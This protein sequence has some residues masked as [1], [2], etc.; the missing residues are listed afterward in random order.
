[1]DGEFEVYGRNG[2]GRVGPTVSRKVGTAR[3]ARTIRAVAPR[4]GALA[5]PNR[6]RIAARERPHPGPRT[7]PV[8]GRPGLPSRHMPA[9]RPRSGRSP[10]RFSAGP[11]VPQPAVRGAWLRA[12]GGPAPVT[13]PRV[14]ATIEP[15]A[16]A[17][18]GARDLA[19]LAAVFETFVAGAAIRRA[20]MAA[21]LLSRVA[22]PDDVRALRLA[23]RALD[24]RA[25]N[26]L[27]G[28]GCGPS[29]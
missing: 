9:P 19:R 3:T 6:E 5:P 18:W 8:L 20:T 14:L 2:S 27:L 26:A 12:R 29:A 21:S 23:L 13:L 24:S 17:D 15:V 25:A 4:P 28:R 10:G 7:A 1:M 11:S 22:D 16:P